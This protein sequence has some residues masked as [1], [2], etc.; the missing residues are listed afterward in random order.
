MSR[1]SR[2]VLRVVPKRRP[3][4]LEVIVER[5]WV[6]RSRRFCRL[7]KPVESLEEVLRVQRRP[8]FDQGAGSSSLSFQNL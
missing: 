1:N 5:G 3:S 2:V 7:G 6:R 8:E 4:F